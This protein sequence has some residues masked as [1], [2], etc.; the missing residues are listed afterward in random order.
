MGGKSGRNEREV[1]YVEGII[2]RCVR[3]HRGRYL[4]DAWGG[5]EAGC[6]PVAECVAQF[7]V[8]RSPL[9]LTSSR[10]RCALQALSALNA[11]QGSLA[12]GDHGKRRDARSAEFRPDHA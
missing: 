3:R 5:N 1:A 4:S 11:K 2:V 9:S 10:S 7:M 6:F 8:T 12:L